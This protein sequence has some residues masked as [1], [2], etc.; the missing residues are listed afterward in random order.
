M[1]AR[2][3]AVPMLKTGKGGNYQEWR[4]AVDARNAAMRDAN[5]AVTLRQ[6]QMRDQQNLARQNRDAAKAAGDDAAVARYQQELNDINRARG[7][8]N[9]DTG[10]YSLGSDTTSQGRIANDQLQAS[11][12]K[13]Q[14]DFKARTGMD[15]D[16]SNPQHTRIMQT[17]NMSQEAMQIALGVGEFNKNYG[18]WRNTIQ[19]EAGQ[20][21]RKSDR[22]NYETERAMNAKD[23]VLDQQFR[24]DLLANVNTS[25][26]NVGLANKDREYFDAYNKNERERVLRDEIYGPAGGKEAWEA[27]ERARFEKNVEA[28]KQEL[29]GQLRDAAALSSV[30]QGAF[31]RNNRKSIAADQ[32]NR[33]NPIYNAANPNPP[34]L[35]G[36][37]NN[38]SI[39]SEGNLANN[40]TTTEFSPIPA[41]MR[42]AQA[43]SGAEP[44]VSGRPNI[45]ALNMV[46]NAVARARAN[47]ATT[48]PIQRATVIPPAPGAIPPAGRPTPAAQPTAPMSTGGMMTPADINEPQASARKPRGNV[49]TAAARTM[50]P[51][52]SAPR[53]S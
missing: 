16:A 2:G 14:D 35:R 11:W 40:P 49:V 17:P 31:D 22:Q 34:V 36:L 19:K 4:S 5:I 29:S 12:K 24:K 30:W 28:R 53:L 9:K 1:R 33:N 20:F 23:G 41:N 50:G 32:L 37:E 38:F 15:Y 46:G 48:P 52:S 3:M 27:Q 21:Q 18:D 42:N 25:N 7:N 51:N 44:T 10:R 43:Q 26:L 39:D 45:P 47:A 13:K 6:N 8:L